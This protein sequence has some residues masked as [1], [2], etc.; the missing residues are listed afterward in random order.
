MSGQRTRVCALAVRALVRALKGLL[1]LE[2]LQHRGLTPDQW[3]IASFV[4]II[5][6]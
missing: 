1:G 5:I 4:H 3:V 6:A 2:W